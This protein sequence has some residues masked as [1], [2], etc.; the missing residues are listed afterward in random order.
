MSLEDLRK[1][2]DKT[3]AKIIRLIAERIRISEE[4]GKEK[5]RQGRQIGDTERERKVL[6]NV[7]KMARDEKISP[8]DIES[9]YRQIII[10]SKRVQE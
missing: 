5:K 7:R 2:V 8:E 3:D 10:A 6:E 1:K 4:I 9:I